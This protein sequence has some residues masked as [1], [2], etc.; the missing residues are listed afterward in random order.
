MKSMDKSTKMPKAAKGKAAPVKGK[1]AK[2]MAKP[3]MKY[4]KKGK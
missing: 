4:G 3:M 2:E 1:A